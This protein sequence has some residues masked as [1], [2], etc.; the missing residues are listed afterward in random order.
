MQ[1][2]IYI[3]TLIYMS[4]SDFNLSTH[5]KLSVCWPGIF[6][7]TKAHLFVVF[8]RESYR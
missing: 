8:C 4:D 5:Q 3:I 6:R 7:E 2:A 1:D